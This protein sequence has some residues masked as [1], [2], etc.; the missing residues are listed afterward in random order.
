MKAWLRMKNARATVDTP[1]MRNG[2][3][4]LKQLISSCNGECN[5][6]RCFSAKELQTATNNY[7]KSRILLDDCVYRL[8][9]GTLE[10]RPI[11]IKKFHPYYNFQNRIQSIIDE[12]VVASQMSTHK[13]VLKL[14]GCSLETEIPILVYEFTE[15][16]GTLADTLYG[17]NERG[18]PPLPWKCRLKVAKDI[19]HAFAYLHTG[20]SRPIIHRDVTPDIFFLDQQ[21]VAKLFDLS[22]CMSIPDGESHIQVSRIVGR[23]GYMAPEYAMHGRANEKSDVF[24]F[25]MLLLEILSGQSISCLNEKDD[26]PMWEHSARVKHYIKSNEFNK[27]VDPTILTEAGWPEKEQQL[28]DFTALAFRCISETEDDRPTMTDVAKQLRQIEQSA[29]C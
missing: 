12:I 28:Q 14:L 27:I 13:N 21:N 8:Y 23:K 5:P 4:L 9:K 22:L 18:L 3:M 25:G 29:T 17:S 20:F 7:D 1:L 10:G 6:I 16:N 26:S 24:S 2:G 19:A 15:S 11:C